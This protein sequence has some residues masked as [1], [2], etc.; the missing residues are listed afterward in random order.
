MG[1]S[2]PQLQRSRRTSSSTSYERKS[3]DRSEVVSKID[4]KE[5]VFIAM[6]SE[7]DKAIAE[8]NREGMKALV[9]EI[10][11]HILDLNQLK[12][13]PMSSGNKGRT[14]KTI[15]NFELAIAKLKS[16]YNYDTAMMKEKN[17]HSMA[18]Q[19]SS[20][21]VERMDVREPDI[22]SDL[23]RFDSTHNM[24]R[25]SNRENRTTLPNVAE[26]ENNTSRHLQ[27]SNSLYSNQPQTFED[28][29]IYIENEFEVLKDQVER[30]VEDVNEYY[31]MDKGVFYLY[32]KVKNLELPENSSLNER[33]F[34]LIKELTEFRTILDRKSGELEEQREIDQEINT[35]ELLLDSATENEIIN[36]RKR[37][38]I[39]QETVERSSWSPN[40]NKRKV[41]LLRRLARFLE[42]I[43]YT[44]PSS[45]IINSIEHIYGNL[46][47]I[48]EEMAKIEATERAEAIYNNIENQVDDSNNTENLEEN[49]SGDIPNLQEYD[50]SIYG[51]VEIIRQNM[52]PREPS[53]ENPSDY[54]NFGLLNEGNTIAH[55]AGPK[56]PLP[57]PRNFDDK[58]INDLPKHWQKLNEIFNKD[59]LSE[60]DIA[61]VAD[62]QR[63]TEVARNLFERKI[64]KIFLKLEDCVDL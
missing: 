46:N 18:N 56:P 32:V 23:I 36:L 9:S 49:T 44:S 29:F 2:Q 20:F 64:K 43:A 37:A 34:R 57:L 6:Q 58:I 12:K 15:Y 25:P 10:A 50:E 55:E 42:R 17:K 33:K 11:A 19:S 3:S 14:Q 27:R 41:D 62:I 31:Q 54:E 30:P 63:H 48:Q 4:Q 59:I 53:S 8:N 26:D 7:I 51:N 61:E 52:E 28:T 16:I 22:V 1:N 35:L 21:Y 40:H 45:S 13:V 60:T 47:S 24:H 5:C 38:S 39:L